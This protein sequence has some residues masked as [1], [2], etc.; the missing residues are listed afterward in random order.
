MV[1]WNLG[2]ILLD[3]LLTTHKLKNKAVI[4][5]FAGEPFSLEKLGIGTAVSN[6][7]SGDLKNLLGRMLHHNSKKRMTLDELFR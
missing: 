7:F 6:K 1:V 3:M 4:D 2:S 5:K